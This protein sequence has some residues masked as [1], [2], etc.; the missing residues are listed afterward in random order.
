MI[1]YFLSIFTGLLILFF[2]YIRFKFRFWAAQPVVHYYDMYYWFVNAGIIRKEL[3]EKNR[4]TNF[5]NVKTIKIDN[6]FM[7]KKNKDFRQF[8]FLIQQNYL[9]NEDNIFYPEQNNIVP[10]FQEH[11]HPSFISFYYE[12]ILLE[13]TKNNCTIEDKK[14]I[15]AITSRSL[16]VFINNNNITFDVYYVDYLCVDKKHRKKNIAPQLIQTHEYNQ[17]HSNRKI[18]VSL[19]KREGELT[20]IVPLCAYRTCCFDMNLWSQ[21]S[22][23]SGSILDGDSQNLYYVFS[24]IEEHKK[25]WDVMILSTL[26]NMI[27]LVKSQ[28]VFVK[29]MMEDSNIVGVY[30]FKRLCTSLYKDKEVISCIASING[31]CKNDIFIQGFKLSLFDIVKKNPVF[32]YLSIEE[33]GDNHMLL[34]NLC[35]KNKPIITSPTGYFFYNFAYQRVLPNKFFILQT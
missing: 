12:K 30:F 31:G 18:S 25:K 22:A 28:N 14:I 7:N 33:I 21:P 6:V 9:K 26:S 24:F 27:E 15:G 11:S 2:L 13:D 10:Y 32:R 4:Y 16:K 5:T 17:S 35:K 19:F 3:P 8:L 23:I 1:L 20:S 34:Q 29:I